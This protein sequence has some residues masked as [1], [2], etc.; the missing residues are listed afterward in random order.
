LLFLI[1]NA[2]EQ[3]PTDHRLPI[4]DFNCIHDTDNG[5]IN[6]TVIATERQ[7]RGTALHDQDRLVNACADGVDGYEMALFVL[8]I[9][10]HQS[11]NQQLAPVQA[12]VFPRGD[13]RSDNAS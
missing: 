6:R 4:T 9:H 1:D 12:V 5:S 8:T 11:R 2:A 7:S 3:L 10:A 13:Y